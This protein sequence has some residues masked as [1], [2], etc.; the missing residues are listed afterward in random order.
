MVEQNIST[1]SVIP[2]QNPVNSFLSRRMRIVLCMGLAAVMAWGVWR[3]SVP[4]TGKQGAEE[5]NKIAIPAEE[6]KPL[7]INLNEKKYEESRTAA[8]ALLKKYPNDIN[9]LQVIGSSYLR[10]GMETS[11]AALIGKAGEVFEQILT[12]I[13]KHIGAISD[14]A[15]VKRLLGKY[16][17]GIAIL[18][19]AKL[20]FPYAQSSLD[21]DLAQMREEARSARAR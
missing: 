16:D 15:T 14:L 5:P 8:G 18:E 20:D 1:G 10:Q 6:Y 11:D 2:P 21:A 12:L 13:P 9:A 19:Q 4:F 17:E 3:Y 7:Q